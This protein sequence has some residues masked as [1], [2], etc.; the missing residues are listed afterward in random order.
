MTL[1]PLAEGIGAGEV[2]QLD[3]RIERQLLRHR[4][5]RGVDHQAD[6]RRVEAQFGE[7][8]LCHLDAHRHRQVRPRVSL[9]QH[10]VAGGQAGEQ[11]R[12]GVPGREGRTGDHQRQAARHDVPALVQ[13]QRIELALRLEPL[14]RLRHLGHRPP[15]VGHSF[16]TTVLGM[17]AAGLEG[18]HESLARG[19]HHRMSQGRA[20]RVE[21]FEDFQTGADPRLRAGIAPGRQRLLLTCQQLFRVVLIVADTKIEAVGRTLG[22]CAPHRSRTLQHERPVEQ[23]LECRLCALYRRLRV[24]LELLAVGR[25]VA[26]FGN[27]LQRAVERGAVVVEQFLG[28]TGGSGRHRVDP[29]KAGGTAQSY[30]KRC[31]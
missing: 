17:R 19:V 23:R 30:R 18:H 28:G 11:A 29:R 21:A 6:Q 8:L 24:L 10:R 31:A 5:L 13:V 12:I 20:Q 27:G 14:R 25:P 16:Q 26:A 9:D 22:T 2:D 15:G 7:H 3:P 1:Q 4:R